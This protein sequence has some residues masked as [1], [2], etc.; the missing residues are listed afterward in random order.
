MKNI[1]KYNEEIRKAIEKNS[2]CGNFIKPIILKHFNKS[3]HGI[4]C[5]TCSMLQLLWANEEYKEPEIDWSNVPVD[6]LIWVR[7]KKN[8]I[9]IQQHFA[10][11]EDDKV[12]A[13]KHGTTSHTATAGYP[14]TLPEMLNIIPWN[15][16]KLA[17]PEEK[18]DE[19]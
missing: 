17:E 9:W 5:A 4:V 15:F 18:E 2:L 19:K 12:Y 1:E 11:Y 14:T 16:A 7:N 8:D 10:K 6:S 3:C 13:W